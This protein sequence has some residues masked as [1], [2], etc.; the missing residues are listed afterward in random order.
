[1]HGLRVLLYHSISADGARDRLTV[2]R[3]QL[4]QQFDYLR[5]K[6]YTAILLSDLIAYCDGKKTLPPNPVLITFDDG[7]L[8]NVDIAYPLAK[9]YGIKINLFVV[10]VFMKQGRY[11]E[12]P[13]LQ[14][15]DIEQLD[16]SLVEIGLHSYD[17]S[18]YTDLVP[19]EIAADLERCLYS[20]QQMGIPYQPCLA[21]P[22]GAWPRRKDEAQDGFFELLEQK[23]IRLAFRIGNRINRLPLGQKFLIQRLDIRGN[24]SFLRFRMSMAFGKKFLGMPGLAARIKSWA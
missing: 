21:Y 8:N 10:P 4:E 16:P 15:E 14:P 13:C 1:M 9:Q 23:G 11:R 7:F 19:A 20:L 22:F 6:G 12:E 5:R 18:N 2:S 24:E 3:R 17:H